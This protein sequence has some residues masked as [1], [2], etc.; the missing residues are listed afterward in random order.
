MAKLFRGIKYGIGAFF[1]LRK[2]KKDIS[3][4][5]QARKLGTIALMRKILHGDTSLFL[6]FLLFIFSIIKVWDYGRSYAGIDFYQ[7]W[8]IGQ[9]IA[10]S[11]PPNIYSDEDR[12]KIGQEFLQMSYRDSD[13]L[14]F[15]LAAENRKVFE[16]Y[17]SPFL[18]SL[19]SVFSSGDFDTDYRRYQFFCLACTI[20]AIMTLCRLLG[21]SSIT[22]MLF[23][24][25]FT[26]WFEPFLS[27]MRVGNVNQI[28]LAFLTLFLWFQSRRASKV[29]DFL[30]GV[31][32][33]FS[34]MFK[35]NLIFVLLLLSLSSL[36]NRRFKKITFEYIG[37][38]SAVIS[39]FIFSSILFGSM[40]PWLDWIITMPSA[41][42]S[43]IT[44]N[45]GN[46]SPAMLIFEQFGFKPSNYLTVALLGIV[47]VFI[48]FGRRQGG[49]EAAEITGTGPHLERPFLE[50]NLMAG[51]GCL[52][53]LLSAPLAWLHYFVLIIPIAIYILRPRDNACSQRME[54]TSAIHRSLWAAA[55]TAIAIT[56]AQMVFGIKTMRSLAF[57]IST[58]TLIL[59][60]LAVCELKN[61]KERPHCFI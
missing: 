33:G 37:I 18:Y 15:R 44:V 41:P 7:F 36:I 17:S 26:V 58:G 1:E 49:V 21:Y 11:N 31:I 28:Q 14:R 52:V 12:R 8:V 45:L 19:F 13:S 57:S 54:K 5:C 4:S 20:F 60:I 16:T 51:L 30:S 24:V 6:V 27:D 42:D 32:L 39:A 3:H 53:Y 2:Y 46:F 61:M 47:T 59:F 38:I 55:V 25:M 23:V 29:R 34:V 43:I 48:W 9:V 35:L 50:S 40:R 56:P 10:Q 22:A